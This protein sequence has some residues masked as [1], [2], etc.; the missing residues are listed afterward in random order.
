MSD[1]T[2]ADCIRA[3]LGWIAETKQQFAITINSP[4]SR[5]GLAGGHWIKGT[6]DGGNWQAKVYPGVSMSGYGIPEFPYI[7]K[8]MMSDGKQ[9]VL[10][11]DRGWDVRPKSP[12]VKQAYQEIGRAAMIWVQ[13]HIDTGRHRRPGS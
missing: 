13:K 10:N 1:M 12:E 9:L 7:S 6:W 8:L 4:M 3:R 2:Q 5:S 11:Y